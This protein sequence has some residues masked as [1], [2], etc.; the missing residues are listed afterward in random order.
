MGGGRTRTVSAEVTQPEQARQSLSVTL[1]AFAS[2]VTVCD[3][4]P[5]GLGTPSISSS[6]AGAAPRSVGSSIGT[7]VPTSSLN[8]PPPL[9]SSAAG[10]V[11][12]A[13]PPPPLGAS[14]TMQACAHAAVS[15]PLRLHES[16]GRGCPPIRPRCAAWQMAEWLRASCCGRTWEGAMKSSRSMI[17]SAPL[18]FCA[19]VYH[20]SDRQGGAAPW[21]G[22][23]LLPQPNRAHTGA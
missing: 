19:I 2:S 20:L 1:T 12:E 13:P 18:K 11:P 4:P 7:A 15:Q 16:K 14:G 17:F 23:A 21:R 9:S 10:V 8:P 3:Q 6:I 5:L 22:S